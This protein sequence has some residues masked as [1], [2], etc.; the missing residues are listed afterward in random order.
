MNI[1]LKASTV[2]AL[3]L[4]FGGTTVQIYAQRCNGDFVYW[5]R[6]QKGELIDDKEKLDMKYRRYDLHPEPWLRRS[7]IRCI[8]RF[9]W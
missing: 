6:D 4:I 9:T 2:A 8:A 5:V 7:E 1:L 3:L